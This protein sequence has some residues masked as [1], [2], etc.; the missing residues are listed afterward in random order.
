MRL[1]KQPLHIWAFLLMVTLV[2]GACNPSTETDEGTLPAATETAAPALTATATGNSAGTATPPDSRLLGTPMLPSQPIDAVFLHAA[3]GGN[4]YYNILGF[5][6]TTGEFLDIVRVDQARGVRGYIQPD[7]WCSEG[8]RFLVFLQSAEGGFSA[9]LID[10]NEMTGESLININTL[11]GFPGG[12]VIHNGVIWSPTC[13]RLAFGSLD[14]EALAIYL[15]LYDLTTRSIIR[16]VEIPSMPAAFFTPSLIPI[17]WTPDGEGI[18][19]ASDVEEPEGGQVRGNYPARIYRVSTSTGEI[20]TLYR[21]ESS[22]EGAAVSPTNPDLLAL[23]VGDSQGVGWPFVWNVLLLNTTTGEEELL[24]DQVW[25]EVHF[26]FSPDGNT[27]AYS[28]EVDGVMTLCFRDI[29]SGTVTC[30]ED[31]RL[32]QS[33]WIQGLAWLPDSQFVAVLYPPTG[34]GTGCRDVVLVSREGEFEGVLI[35][36]SDE[37][38]RTTCGILT[39]S[40]NPAYQQ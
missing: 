37:P 39:F 5:N 25:P 2:M 16:L 7:A 26:A 13:D 18:I 38:E 34:P 22:L 33:L 31:I 3:P 30:S 4:I 11:F 35:P 36:G 28:A 27:L 24:F 6:A 15:G 17:G 10:L 14:P 29:P 9:H 8:G 21:V 19:Y 23:Q 20:T 40:W 12:L 32:R 1:A